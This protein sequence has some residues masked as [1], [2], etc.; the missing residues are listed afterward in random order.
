M[1][2]YAQADSNDFFDDFRP[3][4]V[5]ISPGGTLFILSGAT[6]DVQSG[7]TFTQ[8]SMFINNASDTAVQVQDGSG[9]NVFVIDTNGNEQVTVS[10]PTNNANAFTVEKADATSVFKV[11]TSTESVTIRHSLTLGT[12]GTPIINVAAGAANTL[13]IFPPGGGA[14][15]K[16]VILRGNLSVSGDFFNPTLFELQSN[17]ATLEKDV[18]TTNQQVT[19]KMNVLSALE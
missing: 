6:L 3:E 8:A 1:R 17:M 18:S 13:H 5:R 11:K 10:T 4:D 19:H 12:G 9:S 15:D 14:K 2:A 7:A 16:T